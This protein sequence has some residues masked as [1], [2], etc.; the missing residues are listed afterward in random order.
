MCLGCGWS[1]REVLGDKEAS[2]SRNRRVGQGLLEILLCTHPGRNVQAAI[3]HRTT[4]ALPGVFEAWGSCLSPC[5]ALN[6][7]CSTRSPRSPRSPFIFGTASALPP[8]D[9]RPSTTSVGYETIN[10]FRRESGERGIVM[11]CVPAW[12][13]APQH[14]HHPLPRNLLLIPC[15]TTYCSSPASQPTAPQ[16]RGR[17]NTRA[18][19]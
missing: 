9:M 8:S 4:G 16:P 11:Q 2:S 13:T 14:L 7:S 12:C 6:I 15:L 3:V 19:I 17:G 18:R 10:D 5:A 1:G